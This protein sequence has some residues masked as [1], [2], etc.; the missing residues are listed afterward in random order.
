MSKK[1]NAD[2]LNLDK[3]ILSPKLLSGEISEKDLHHLLKKLPDLADDAE[4]VD[5]D[6]S[7]K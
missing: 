4:E 7:E 3:R 1:V 2:L 6:V 5:P